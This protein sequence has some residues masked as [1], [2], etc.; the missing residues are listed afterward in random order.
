MTAQAQSEEEIKA[1]FLF[2]FARYVEWPE[3]AFASSAT[4]V[5]IC[6]F[7]SEGFSGVVS[8]IVSGKNVGDRPVAVSILEDLS[9]TG[10]CHIL[11]LDSASELSSQALIEGLSETHV[12]TVSD[13]RGFAEEGGVANFFR[14]GDRIRFEINPSAAERAGLKISSR[15]LRLAKVVE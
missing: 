12:F 11:Y 3:N 8:Q 15:L 7:A 13:R 6:M 4:P 14:L 10:D 5:S 1:A 9:L 2:N